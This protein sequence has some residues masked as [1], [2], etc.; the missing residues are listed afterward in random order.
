MS[1]LLIDAGIRIMGGQIIYDYQFTRGQFIALK[2]R[3]TP[4]N[5]QRLADFIQTHGLGPSDF[6]FPCEHPD[7]RPMRQRVMED[8]LVESSDSRT[9]NRADDLRSGVSEYKEWKRTET[10]EESMARKAGAADEA[11]VAQLS[12]A[13]RFTRNELA[14]DHASWGLLTLALASDCP[15]AEI[16]AAQRRLQIARE[17][18]PKDYAAADA[19]YRAKVKANAELRK[20]ELQGRLLQE[21]EAIEAQIQSVESAA[22]VDAT[23]IQ[24]QEQ[25]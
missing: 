13:E 2:W 15:A 7:P 12:E 16:S 6:R 21:Q 10:W 25:N 14:I 22:W 20:A 19:E 9:R 1:Q 17:L 11:E 8:G 18:S 4:E 5:Q 3:D 24:Q 23:T